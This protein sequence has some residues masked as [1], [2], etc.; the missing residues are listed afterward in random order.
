MPAPDNNEFDQRGDEGSGGRHEAYPVGNANCYQWRSD[1]DDTHVGK[2]VGGE[3]TAPGIEQRSRPDQREDEQ[4]EDERETPHDA[5][6][7][8]KRSGMAT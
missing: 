3:G 5:H 8:M 2:H 1:G 4:P 6:P 7:S